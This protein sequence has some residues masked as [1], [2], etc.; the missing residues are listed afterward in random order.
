MLVSRIASPYPG[1]T[2]VAPP[3]AKDEKEY[4]TRSL[5][6]FYH[7]P[8]RP[9]RPEGFLEVQLSCSLL[10]LIQFFFFLTPSMFETFSEVF[11]F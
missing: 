3:A 8:H 5:F 2:H 7:P 1:A 10:H 6:F 4:R 9:A 11:L